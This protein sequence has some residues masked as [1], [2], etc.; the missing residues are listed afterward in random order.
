[1]KCFTMYVEC[2]FSFKTMWSFHITVEGFETKQNSHSSASSS[3]YTEF[4]FERE[5]SSFPVVDNEVDFIPF[6]IH[7]N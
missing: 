7:S 5:M 2:V 1:M 4:T 3:C 6:N